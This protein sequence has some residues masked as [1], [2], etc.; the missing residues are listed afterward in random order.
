M[1]VE[2]VLILND[3]EKHI[4]ESMIK[5]IDSGSMP[6]RQKTRDTNDI[7]SEISY[8][9]ISKKNEKILRGVMLDCPYKLRYRGGNRVYFSAWDCKDVCGVFYDVVEIAYVMGHTNFYIKEVYRK[10][11]IDL[12]SE[13]YVFCS[14]QTAV[15]FINMS[16]YLKKNDDKDSYNSQYIFSVFKETSS[17]FYGPLIEKLKADSYSQIRVL[18]IWIRGEILYY[19]I[20]DGAVLRPEHQ[21]PLTAKED[22]DINRKIFKATNELS[23]MTDFNRG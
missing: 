10:F 8:E 18:Q 20:A 14:G 17:G 11:E 15:S 2:S 9:Y 7:H 4:A 5:K 3:I 12:N 16:E 13:T 22:A 19:V 6:A 1:P 23:R 21:R